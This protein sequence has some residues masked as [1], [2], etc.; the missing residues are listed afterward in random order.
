MFAKT[1]ISSEKGIQYILEIIVCDLSIHII[2]QPDLRILNSIMEQFLF[3]ISLYFQSIVIAVAVA[4]IT[5]LVILF[6][7]IWKLRAKGKYFNPIRGQITTA[8]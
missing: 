1:N 3:V 5:V 6:F 4:I 8:A 2:D 7:G